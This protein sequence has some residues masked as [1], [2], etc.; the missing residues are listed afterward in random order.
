[1]RDVE[2]D[3]STSNDESNDKVA[4]QKRQRQEGVFQVSNRMSENKFIFIFYI[5]WYGV[6][7]F[8]KN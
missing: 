8:V 2:G 3:S 7:E 6:D 4:P 1:L 5:I